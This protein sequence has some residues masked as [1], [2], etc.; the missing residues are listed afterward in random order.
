MSMGLVL[1]ATRDHLRLRRGWNESVC[2][3]QPNAVPPASAGDWYV[4]IDEHSIAVD[5]QAHRNER[6]AI[7]IALWRRATA[8]VGDR[9]GNQLMATDPYWTAHVTLDALERQ[10]VDDLHGDYGLL[11]KA[12][13]AVASLAPGS[14]GFC[15]A[16]FYQGRG[17]TELLDQHGGKLKPFAG[18][19]AEWL[20]RRLNFVG[21]SRTTA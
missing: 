14:P 20:V 21:L 17:R 10:I 13:E 2:G 18:T 16:L 19:S 8:L 7:E 4:A 15:M 9:A 12:N 3:V 6:F 5:G 11:A 1:L